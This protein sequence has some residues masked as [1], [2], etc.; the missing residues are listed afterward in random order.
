MADENQMDQGAPTPPQTAE[1]VERG[2]S[3]AREAAED[4]R[5]A[6]GITTDEY[7]GRAEGVWDDARRRVRNFQGDSE[8]Y[9]RENPT[10]AVFIALGIGFLLG[11]TF[12]R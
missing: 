3:H 8:Q 9:V 5:S 10:K 12:R 1:K 6:A 2:V 4:L 11:F 7:L